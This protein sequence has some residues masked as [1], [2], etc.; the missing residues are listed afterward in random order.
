M[1]SRITLHL[2][3][4]ARSIDGDL[5]FASASLI[6]LSAAQSI[7]W[8]RIRFTHHNSPA[9]IDPQM[10]VTIEESTV[11]YDDHGHVVD[12]DSDDRHAHSM[13]VQK[14]GAAGVTN[15][16]YELRAIHLGDRD[17]RPKG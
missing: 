13:K 12:D 7:V 11:R 2:R 4:Q 10:G 9:G 1:M 5:S 8:S 15:E 14:K 16:W 6:S 17:E 3:K